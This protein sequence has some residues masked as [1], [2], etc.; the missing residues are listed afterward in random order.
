[1]PRCDPQPG[2]NNPVKLRKGHFGKGNFAGSANPYNTIAIV[3]IN[4]QRKISF[5]NYTSMPAPPRPAITP[6]IISKAYSTMSTK[7]LI[8]PS[9]T[10]LAASLLDL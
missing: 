1:M 9:L 3:M 2:H 6:K 5:F 7:P 4:S 10:H 8:A